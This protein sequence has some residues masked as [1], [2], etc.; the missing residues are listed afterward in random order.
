MKCNLNYRMTL[1]SKQKKH[2]QQKLQQQADS[3]LETRTIWLNTIE[4][5]HISCVSLFGVV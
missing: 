1:R 4:S 5:Y 2:I 3:N